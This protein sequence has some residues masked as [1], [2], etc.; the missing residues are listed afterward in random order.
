MVSIFVVTMWAHRIPAVMYNQLSEFRFPAA[1]VSPINE[2]C[3]KNFFKRTEFMLTVHFPNE[4]IQRVLFL[5]E[6]LSL[7]DKYHCWFQPYYHFNG[8]YIL[9]LNTW[10]L[11][12]KI[13]PNKC[14]INDFSCMLPEICCNLKCLI[15]KK[16]KTL[17]IS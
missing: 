8:F 1:A 13:C 16:K 10:K 4:W 12:C 3:E 7:G 5:P 9:D 11:Y 6:M 15:K 2:N 14:T 17:H